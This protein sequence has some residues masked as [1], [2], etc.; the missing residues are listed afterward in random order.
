MPLNRRRFL[1]TAGHAAA[2]VLP[3]ALLA[4]EHNPEPTVPIHY[5]PRGNRSQPGGHFPV[6]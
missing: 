6:N 2:L 1:Q 5:L 4:A 3:T